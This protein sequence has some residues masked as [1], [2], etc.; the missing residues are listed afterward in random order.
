MMK[1]ESPIT[2][3]QQAEAKIEAYLKR[4]LRDGAGAMTVV[5]LRQVKECDLLIANLEQPSVVLASYVQRVLDSDYGLQEF[6]RESDA[7]WGRVFGERPYF[8][9]QDA[10]P[11]PDDPYTIESVRAALFDLMQRLN[12]SDC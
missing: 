2:R 8:E 3:K 4:Y 5:L 12:E 10:P 6:V 7:E 11:H 9:K 1:G